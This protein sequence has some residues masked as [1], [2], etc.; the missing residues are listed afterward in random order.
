MGPRAAPGQLEAVHGCAQALL[1]DAAQPALWEQLGQIY[2]AAQDLEEALR[3]Y[4]QAA[5][6]QRDHPYGPL[7]THIARLQQVLP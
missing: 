7:A 5:R 2:E 4:Q 3:C 1:R 6:Y